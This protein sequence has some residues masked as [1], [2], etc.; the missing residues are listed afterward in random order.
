MRRSLG[1]WTH[2]RRFGYSVELGAEFGA[3]EFR[4]EPTRRLGR[5]AVGIEVE[6]AF[7]EVGLQVIG[8]EA[9]DERLPIEPYPAF[10]ARRRDSA[11]L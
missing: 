5:R 9:E 4:I 10:P 2:L 3:S 7:G 8:A 1:A 11:A 6:P